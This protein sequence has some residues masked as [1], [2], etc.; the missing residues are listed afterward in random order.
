LGKDKGRIWR[1]VPE[2]KQK[3]R[4]RPN[5]SKAT[6]KELVALLENDDAWWRTT[7][8]RLLLQRQDRWADAELHELLMFN[9]DNSLARIHAAWLAHNLKNLKE[10]HVFR[11]LHN[12]NPRVR[13]QGV[14]LAE[15]R[16]PRSKAFRN[17]LGRMAKDPDARVRFQVALTLGEL[18]YDAILG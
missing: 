16:L 18:D 1:I 8:Q 9:S 14:L 7:A 11:M 10:F 12:E 15:S 6:T 2:G 5:L 4:P 17:S 3:P 13:E